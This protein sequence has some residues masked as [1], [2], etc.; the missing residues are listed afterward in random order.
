MV[1]E[2]LIQTRR[3]IGARL[4]AISWAMRGA[5]L[6]SKINIGPASR[7]DYPH[8]VSL[9]DRVTL[10]DSVWFKLVGRQATLTIGEFSFIGRGSEFDVAADLQI[11]SNVL[12]A[13]RVFIADHSHNCLMG[14]L[15]NNQGCTSRPIQIGNDVWIGTGAT[16]LAGVTIGDGAV[17][18][19]GAIVRSDVGKNE[20]WAGVPARKIRDRQKEL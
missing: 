9:G 17:I 15:I 8:G 3:L 6:G 14:K 20:I 10:E 12:I 19:A 5:T 4:R 11:G 2:R 16:I 1:L 7:V 18:G 13:P